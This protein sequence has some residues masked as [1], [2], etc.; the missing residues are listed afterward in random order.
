MRGK[1][2][3][4]SCR[5]LIN[6]IRL[7]EAQLAKV[8]VLLPRSTYEGEEVKR[9][10]FAGC[11]LSVIARIQSEFCVLPEERWPHKMDEYAMAS[12][13]IE[14][15]VFTWHLSRTHRRGTT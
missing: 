3:C 12:S 11:S 13:S 9:N 6:I 15:R 14:G 2:S 7:R 8:I 4:P 5:H 1:H 10:A